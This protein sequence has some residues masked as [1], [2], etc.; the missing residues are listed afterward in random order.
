MTTIRVVDGVR[1]LA[2]AVLC[3]VGLRLAAAELVCPPLPAAA[4]RALGAYDDARALVWRV[5]AAD[6]ASSVLLGTM[7]L[8]DPRVTAIAATVQPQFARAR[9]FVLEVLLD[10]LAVTRFQQAMFDAGGGR[11]E[12]TLGAPLFD[13]TAQRLAAYG[14]APEQAGALKP[15]AAFVILGL[16]PGEQ[17][18]PLDLALLARARESGMTVS[19][20][21][22]VDEQI[23]VFDTLAPAAQT[24]LLR[25]T[26]CHYERL[27]DEIDTMIEYYAAR[28]LGALT[29]VSLEHADA[30]REALLEALLWAR[31]ERMVERLLPHL[32]A[33]DAF[34][35]VGALHLPGDR[36]ILHL[37]EARGFRVEAIY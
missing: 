8:G 21:E 16:P 1:L 24:E 23:A 14:I 33:G 10:E 34:V 26:V 7:H 3:L 36:G 31:S 37:L 15:W 35:A 19:A 27:Q 11:L 2:L 12:A 5:T 28:D 29:R 25:E 6:G 4:P 20:L 22:T 30:S 18:L 9:R 13:A 32:A 17:A